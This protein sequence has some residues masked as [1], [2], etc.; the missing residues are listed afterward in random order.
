MMGSIT[1]M[2]CSIA[3]A[4]AFIFGMIFI[5]YGSNS[6]KSKKDKH[7]LPLIIF[8]WI[9]AIASIVGLVISFILFVNTNGGIT[10]TYIL[11]F[12]SPIFIFIGFVLCVCIG[13][14]S[15]SDAYSKNK[16]DVT[17][18]QSIVKGWCL[19][20]LAI[21]MVV[22]IVVTFAILINSYQA[23]TKNPIRMM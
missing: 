2:I 3:A 15:L 18:K 10:G 11:L 14:Y 17:R 23:T 5:L 19:L 13:A 16:D 9:L 12:I 4:F 1:F 20:A 22:V 7:L 8:G 21:T 6:N